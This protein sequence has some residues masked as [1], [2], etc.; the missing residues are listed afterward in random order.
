VLAQAAVVPRLQPDGLDVVVVLD[1]LGELQQ[2]QVE[3]EAQVVGLVEGV[4]SQAAGR[5]G[6]SAALFVKVFRRCGSDS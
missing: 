2:R 5:D 4:Q 1:P 3:L 6:I